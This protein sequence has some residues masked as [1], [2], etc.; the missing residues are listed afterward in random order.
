MTKENIKLSVQ[1]LTLPGQLNREAAEKQER[2]DWEDMRML[3]NSE[4]IKLDTLFEDI[5]GFDM[6]IN[7]VGE[8]EFRK[9][10]LPSQSYG[11]DIGMDHTSRE[12]KGN[13]VGIEDKKAA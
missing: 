1:E 6:R 2:Q 9:Y 10:F 12:V 5:H 8:D 11:F 13:L 7:E 4:R 3:V